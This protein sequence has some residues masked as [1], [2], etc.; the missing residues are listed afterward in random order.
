[1]R[2][3]SRLIIVLALAIGLLALFLQNVDLRRVG[4]DIS[5][6][7]PIWLLLSLATMLANLAIRARRW[8]Y[9]Q[10]GRAHV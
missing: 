2:T 9:L 8:Q 1:M 4:G 3:Y 6:A 10:I 7:R 5:R